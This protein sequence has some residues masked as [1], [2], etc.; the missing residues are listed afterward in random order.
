MR[1]LTTGILAVLLCGVI[2]LIYLFGGNTDTAP[3]TALPLFPGFDKGAVTWI[4]AA[5]YMK[6]EV[7][8]ER[9][10]GA[11]WVMLAPYEDDARKELVGQLLD[12]LEANVRTPVPLKPG[13]MDLASKGL[14]PPIHFIRFR[15]GRGEHT[16][17]LGVRDPFN[18]ETYVMIEGDEHLYRT[19]SNIRNFLELN[20]ENLRDDR[21]FRI[22]ALLVTGIRVDGPEG[23]IME[24]EKK[25]GVWEITGPARV[26][27]ESGK[28]QN[29]ASR[30]TGLRIQ[31]WLP[32]DPKDERVLAMF[33][34]DGPGYRITLTSGPVSRLAVIGP[35][36]IGP[37]GDY[38]CIRD[39]EERI[40]SINRTEMNH[41]LKI[42][43]LNYFRSLEILK[44]V[45]YKLEALRI[46]RGEKLALELQRI[47]SQDYFKIT[48]PFSANAD[49][50]S[51][52]NEPPIFTFLT[53][54]DGIRI[55][56]AAGFV[57]EGVED[58]SAYGLDPPALDVEL[59]WKEA[60][61]KKSANLLFSKDDGSGLVYAA[62]KDRSGMQSVFRVKSKDLEPLYIDPLLLRDRRVF[63]QERDL[64]VVQ[65]AAFTLGERFKK[66]ER[67]E[68][69][70]FAEDP[71]SRFQQFLNRMVRTQVVRYEA[72][73]PEDF[74]AGFETLTGSIELEK[75]VGAEIT[76]IRYDFGARSGEGWYGRSSEIDRGI[77][78][79]DDPFM[80]EF[81]QLFEDS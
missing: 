29:L 31:S 24:A 53:K 49:N 74:A 79:L 1:F 59:V 11:R 42:L 69:D 70:F 45:R 77:F 13:E 34:L 33:G 18:N 22:D 44:P 37:N 66:I 25:T 35:E 9:K 76:T 72:G 67:D 55:D 60:A 50:V 23:L 38:L 15:D 36:G 32:D 62:K 48:Q 56:G 57:A 21:I 61:T 68:D 47:G 80:E 41:I 16:L 12:A 14:D 71:N 19:G 51:D 54:I 39:D 64:K 58:L 43:Y 63:P 2:L 5:M 81:N 20:P 7:T 27:G 65:V 26:D 28:I 75:K 52:G 3:G 78:Y 17:F 4:E 46:R 40:V 30:L 10:A 73:A 6:R 8:L